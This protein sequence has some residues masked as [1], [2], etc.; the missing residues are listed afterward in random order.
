[1]QRPRV[2][3]G[4][5]ARQDMHVYTHV[6]TFAFAR[7]HAIAP[8]VLKFFAVPFETALP[9]PRAAATAATELAGIENAAFGTF[10]VGRLPGCPCLRAQTT[11]HDAR[12]PCAQNANDTLRPHSAVAHR[13]TN[14]LFCTPSCRRPTCARTSGPRRLRTS[15]TKRPRARSN[16]VS[17]T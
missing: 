1:M 15:R 5:N 10:D 6:L 12:A 3:H 2:Q 4:S 14:F 8:R 11:C 17:G 7:P 16:W 13:C 9:E